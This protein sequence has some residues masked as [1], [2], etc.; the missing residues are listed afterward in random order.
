MP[1]FR[2]S[3]AATL[4]GVSDDTV[5]RW[6]DSGRLPT[7]HDDAGRRAIE[8]ANLAEFAKDL[9]GEQGSSTIPVVAESAR[10]R[11]PGIITRVTR[12]TVMAQVEIQAGPHRLV[13]LM[14]REAADELGLEPGVLAV[15]AVKSTNVVIEMPER[16]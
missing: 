5:R 8:G 14:S 9:A 15:G 4:L 6:A 12:D 16:R 10:N 11:F 13:S 7:I 2:I 1:T 3:E